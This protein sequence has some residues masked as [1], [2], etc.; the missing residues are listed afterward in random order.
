MG[1]KR[2]RQ[3]AEQQ[4]AAPPAAV[5]PQPSGRRYTV[6]LAVPGSVIDN[7]QSMEFAIFVAGQVGWIPA[8]AAKTQIPAR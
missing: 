5:D 1:K 7:T 6:S 4:A 2:T 8:W 3:Q